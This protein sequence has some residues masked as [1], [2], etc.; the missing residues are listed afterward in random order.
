M[1]DTGRIDALLRDA[2]HAIDVVAQSNRLVLRGTVAD[3][4]VKELAED[5]AEEAA[6]GWR[7]DN[8]LRVD[9]RRD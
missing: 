1:A 4:N 6:R 3:E 9:R 7:V 2:A 8:Q 5:R